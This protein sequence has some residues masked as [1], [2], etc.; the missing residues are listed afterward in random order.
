M[1][2]HVIYKLGPFEVPKLPGERHVRV[3]LPTEQTDIARLPVLYMFDGQNIFHDSPSFSGGWYLHH[4][5][6]DLTAAGHVAPIIVGI[7]HGSE[8]RVH[9]LSPFAH[10]DSR[11]ELNHLIRWIVRELRPRINKEFHVSEEVAD[12]AIGGSS[13]GGLAALYAHYRRPDVFGA[14]LC[15]SPSLWFAG[16]KIYEHLAAQPLPW[17]SRIYLDAG[18]HEGDMLADAHRLALQLRQR[19]YDDNSLMFLADPY[20]THS[21]QDWRKRAPSAIELLFSGKHGS[22]DGT[23]LDDDDPETTDQAA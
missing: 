7:D 23:S 2:T 11:G 14:A 9:E 20:G 6:H 15:M 8:N 17:S 5:V 13:M 22:Y 1:A 12:T 19:G 18:Q 4:A 16:H 21:E 10:D 3:Y